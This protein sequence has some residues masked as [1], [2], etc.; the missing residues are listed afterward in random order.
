[1]I[2]SPLRPRHDRYRASLLQASSPSRG[3]PYGASLSF[4][5]TTH[6][7]PP[8]DP[9]SR[10]P[11]SQTS[12]QQAARSIPGRALASSMLDSPCQGSR[13]GFTPPIS[14]S[15]PGTPVIGVALRA[16]LDGPPSGDGVAEHPLGG[17]EV[18]H[19]PDDPGIVTKT[20]CCRARWQ[21]GLYGVRCC[22][23]CQRTRLQARPRV[24]IARGWSWPRVS[25][26]R[27]GRPPRGASGGPLRRLGRARPVH[28]RDPRCVPIASLDNGRRR[29]L[30][31]CKA[32]T[33]ARPA[34]GGARTLK[35][36]HISC[37]NIAAS[38]A[39][40][41]QKRRLSEF[42]H[43]TIVISGFPF[44]TTYVASTAALPPPTFFPRGPSRRRPSRPR[45]P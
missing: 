6:L 16:R 18:G 33:R 32:R 12:R 2:A 28:H 4:A 44:S 45:P 26:R 15:V 19:G 14:T 36:D 7:W 25:R 17:S 5:T 37:V 3:T 9:P 42:A 34:S 22:Q 35:I 27:N 1:M 30:R 20:C 43:S 10:K 29:G 11:A 21:A 38:T 23:H 41:R 31:N 8:S 39:A 24:R 13:T 40:I